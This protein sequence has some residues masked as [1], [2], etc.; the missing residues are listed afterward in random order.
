MEIALNR[1]NTGM[2]LS[3]VK[4]TSGVQLT[5]EE[6]LLNEMCDL[7]NNDIKQLFKFLLDNWLIYE[8]DSP[9]ERYY[10]KHVYSGRKNTL[11]QIL[12]G[13]HESDGIYEFRAK[14][15]KI[16]VDG[17]YEAKKDKVLLIESKGNYELA[18]IKTK[19][20]P[21]HTVIRT[22]YRTDE[23]FREALLETN[24]IS[25][26]DLDIYYK[27]DQTMAKYYD[28]ILRKVVFK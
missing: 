1:H 24:L 19:G 6:V 14:G 4:I 23:A 15:N 20:K 9:N 22:N 16:K 18:S 7:N 27:P 10:V 8:S 25:K 11:Y 26:D 12:L 21:S 28:K 3:D 17:L 2:F 5:L 13:G